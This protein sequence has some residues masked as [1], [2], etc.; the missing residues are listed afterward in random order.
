[1]ATQNLVKKAIKA[2]KNQLFSVAETIYWDILSNEPERPDIL[3]LLAALFLETNRPLDALK[4]IDDDISSKLKISNFYSIRGNAF[5][6]LERFGEAAQSHRDAI[7]LSP[8]DSINFFNLGNALRMLGDEDAAI[9]A[10]NSAIKFDPSLPQPHSNLSAIFSELGLFKEAEA[11]AKKAIENAPHYADAYYNLGNALR[12]QGHYIEATKAYHNVLKLVPNY[13]DA[14]CNLGLTQFTF[15]IAEAANILQ[16]AITINKE[17]SLAR[18]Y[19]GVALDELGRS[20]EAIMTFAGLNK[21]NPIDQ[22]KLKSWEYIKKNRTEKTK[23]LPNSHETLKFAL[24]QAP[25]TGLICEFGVRHGESLRFI[26]ELTNNTVH[27][28]DSFE[29]LPE[30]WGN[31]T[32]GT[33]ST[34]GKLPVVPSNVMLHV[35][36]FNDTLPAFCNN[37]GGG[38]AF[39]N[40]DCDLYSSTQTILISL[41]PKITSGT[42]IVFDDYLINP[43]WEN[44]EHRAFKEVAQIF[45]WKTE[46]I[47]FCIVGKQAVVKIH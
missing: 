30:D 21:K 7:A 43:S 22:S 46:Y 15:S 44:D 5:H 1:M 33:Y 9:E 37:F 11:S 12:E 36:N 32:R 39:A 10:Y 14:I 17:H 3:Q 6:K 4:L 34:N 38:L 24:D 27:G 42:I 23:M 8:S 41:A 31:E 16:T 25:L 47:G 2:H 45:N 40:I 19:L 28:F 18:F 26:S 13:V 20:D 29:G 35:G